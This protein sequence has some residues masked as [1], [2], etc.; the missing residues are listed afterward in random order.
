[1]SRISN[2]REYGVGRWNCRVLASLDRGENALNL[3]DLIFLQRQFRFF[4]FSVS[5]FTFA[6][7]PVQP[8]TENARPRD[9]IDKTR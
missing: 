1:M 6:N 4:V 2:P 8:A 5:V 9:A 3:P 7:C